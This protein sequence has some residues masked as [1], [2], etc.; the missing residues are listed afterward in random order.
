MFERVRRGARQKLQRAVSEVVDD[1][2]RETNAL[3]EQLH[4]QT[5]DALSETRE[6][7]VALHRRVNHLEQQVRRDLTHVMDTDAARQSGDFV[8]AHMPKAPQF[9]HPH[10]TL[11]YALSQVHIPGMALEFGVA[12]GTTLNIIAAELKTEHR[13]FGFDVFSGLPD[14]WRSGF[15]A[16]EFAQDTLPDVLGAELIPGLFEDTLPDFLTEHREPVSFLHLDADLY[17][18]TATVLGL[19]GRRLMAGTII[20]F[21]EFFNYPGWQQHEYRAWQEFV[22]RTGIEFEYL[23]YTASHEQVIARVTAPGVRP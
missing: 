23:G 3:V 2:S 14:T 12:T 4:R 22:S 10:D 18:S 15:A 1:S 20:V 6:E 21:D 17:S 8:L 11:R 9:W 5:M 7:V 19:V 16:G 13:I